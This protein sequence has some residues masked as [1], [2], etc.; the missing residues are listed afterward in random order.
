MRYPDGGGL[1][2]ED[3]A[4]GEWVRLAA[5]AGMEEGVPDREVA[6]RFGVTGCRSTGGAARWP[7][8][9]GQRCRARTGAVPAASSAARSWAHHNHAKPP[10]GNRSSLSPDA[11]S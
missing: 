9:G 3:R 5:A 2:A 10:F 6:T 4:G 8:A 7:P 1:T 11:P